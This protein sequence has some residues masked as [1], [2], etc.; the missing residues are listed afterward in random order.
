MGWL[1]LRWVYS[2]LAVF[3]FSFFSNM[4]RFDIC[5]REHLNMSTKTSA[6]RFCVRV[7]VFQG[8][9][10]KAIATSRD[11]F[12]WWTL[13]AISGQ[14]FLQWLIAATGFSELIWRDASV[15]YWLSHSCCRCSCWYF[16]SNYFLVDPCLLACVCCLVTLLLLSLCWSW[17]LDTI[18][19]STDCWKYK[20]ETEL[21]RARIFVAAPFTSWAKMEIRHG[22]HRK[23]GLSAWAACFQCWWIVGSE[24]NLHYCKLSQHSITVNQRT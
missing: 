7:W 22:D 5:K 12:E 24:N 23:C 2:L 1:L 10:I 6:N 18:A 20:N 14:L 17:F 8:L 3:R 16:L 19:V 13:Y 9:I 4:I 15:K 21:D 11:V